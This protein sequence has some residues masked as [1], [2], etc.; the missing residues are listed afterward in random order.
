MTTVQIITIVI[1]AVACVAA[2]LNFRTA[3]DKLV[4]ERI[5]Q[6]FTDCVPQDLTERLVR[7]EA[8]VDA[9]LTRIDR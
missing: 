9:I 7:L 5:K 1:S 8:K 2:I 6:K 4:D 3:G